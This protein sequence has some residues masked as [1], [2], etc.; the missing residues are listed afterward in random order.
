METLEIIKEK[1]VEYL[2]LDY[3]GFSRPFVVYTDASGTDVGGI[4]FKRGMQKEL[5]NLA[6]VCR[7]L[8]Q[9]D[10]LSKI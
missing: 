9:P 8:N 5:Q 4:Y 7:V 2:V 1:F 10:F 6:F 3:L